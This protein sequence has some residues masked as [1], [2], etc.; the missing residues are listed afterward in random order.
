MKKNRGI[1][2]ITGDVLSTTGECPGYYETKVRVVVDSQV[3]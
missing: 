1:N 2:V 3:G